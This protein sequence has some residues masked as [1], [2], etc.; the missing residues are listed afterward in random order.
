MRAFATVAATLSCLLAGT[1]GTALA[2]TLVATQQPTIQG[3]PAVGKALLC[4][5]G[6]WFRQIGTSFA[7]RVQPTFTFS[8]LLDGFPIADAT[9][10]A[11]API[12]TDGGRSVSCR[13]A[14]SLVVDSRAP[15]GTIT[16]VATSA[17]VSIPAPPPVAPPARR[18][19]T[20]PPKKKVSPCAK[21]R[22]V[23]RTRCVRRQACLRIKN[24]KRRKACIAKIPPVRRR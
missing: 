15:S 21:L 18:P 22:G 14:A 12:A 9:I 5:P 13:V 1:V 8:W 6:T 4:Q 24:A 2:D 20:T 16:A 17:A 10:Q 23:K 19:A 7:V 11:Y 3:T